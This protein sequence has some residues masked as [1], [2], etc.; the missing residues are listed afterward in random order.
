MVTA[1]MIFSLMILL[2]AMRSS[3]AFSSKSTVQISRHSQPVSSMSMRLASSVSANI[4]VTDLPDSLQD[5]A[6]RAAQATAAYYEAMGQSTSRC[7][8]DFDTSIGDETYSLLKTSTEFM[9][10]YVSATCYALIP[11]LMERRQ[12]EIMQAAKLR[13]E[14]LRQVELDAQEPYAAEGD[15]REELA[16]NVSTSS[17]SPEI[18]VGTKP[19]NGPIARIYFPDEGNAALARRDWLL[20]SGAD[21]KVP[22]CCQFS[23]CG[24]VQS[25]DISKDE[26][27]FFFCPN[28]AE[29]DSVEDILAKTEAN[30]LNLRV[31]V[32]VNPKL[33]DMGVTGFGLA[34]RR[35]RE[36]LLDQLPT[37]YY[38]RTLSWGA[39]TR[40]W[41]R[42]FSV[43]QEDE[44]ASGGY[45]LIKT[46]NRL[47]SNPEVEDIY[48]LENGITEAREG[49][50]LLDQFGDFVNGMMRL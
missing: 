15:K 40:Q 18:A 50:G 27:I 5:A 3:S 7:R 22:A 48:D 45:R 14:Q 43:W 29:A 30:A 36:R 26:I 39:L 12:E 31:S 8:I 24:G 4:G 37:A 1:K 35:L 49:G 6:E 25:Q 32:F 19:W 42:E 10:Q 34:G 33:V 16:P 17:S 20:G 13:A 9:Q 11:G 44:A 28:A 23:S 21:A 46:M 2:V 41:P 38:L 47:P